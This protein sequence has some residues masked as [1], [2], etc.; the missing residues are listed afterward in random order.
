MIW[1]AEP[2]TC[3]VSLFGPAFGNGA[4]GRFV[5]N[6][7]ETE[8]NGTKL[9]QPQ[10]SCLASVASAHESLHRLGCFRFGVFFSPQNA[11]QT[12]RWEGDR[13]DWDV[14]LREAFLERELSA[15]LLVMS[16]MARVQAWLP[17]SLYKK[18]KYGHKRKGKAENRR[19]APPRLGC[20]VGTPPK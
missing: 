11:G 13:R 12:Y 20:T 5:N 14:G 18:Y 9:G 8:G 1:S 15:V 3:R 19:A 16:V 7:W 4:E 2:T 17:R 6:L 10:L